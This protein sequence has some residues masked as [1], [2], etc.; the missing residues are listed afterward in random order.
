MSDRHAEESGSVVAPAVFFSLCLLLLLGLLFVVPV[1][2]E[3]FA[4]FG[5]KLPKLTQIVFDVAHLL[6]YNLLVTAG[7]FAALIAGFVVATSS[8]SERESSGVFWAL[9]V[10]V[11]I[12]GALC[13]GVLFLPIF[14]LSSVV[15]P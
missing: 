8:K 1:F 14:H 10:L 15:A 6:K 2:A 11:L 7:I 13:V 12:I 5:A 4:D 3:M 9:S